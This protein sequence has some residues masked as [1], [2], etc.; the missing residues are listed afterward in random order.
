MDGRTSKLLRLLCCDVGSE[1]PIA[2]EELDLGFATGLFHHMSEGE[3]KKFCKMILNRNV[4]KLLVRERIL[5]PGEKGQEQK[6]AISEAEA[7]GKGGRFIYLRNQNWYENLQ[8]LDKTIKVSVVNSIV[9]KSPASGK[10][11]IFMNIHLHPKN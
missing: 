7:E 1:L 8:K 4:K 10:F 11:Y 6:M 5:A 9:K 3:C 2:S